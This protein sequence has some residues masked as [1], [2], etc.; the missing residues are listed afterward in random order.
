MVGFGIAMSYYFNPIANF[1][2]LL[3]PAYLIVA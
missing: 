3:Q 1:S 2:V